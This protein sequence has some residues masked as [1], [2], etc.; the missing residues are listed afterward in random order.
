MTILALHGDDRGPTFG[1]TLRLFMGVGPAKSRI[2]ALLAISA[3]GIIASLVVPLALKDLVNFHLGLAPAGTQAALVTILVGALTAGALAEGFRSH[4]SVKAEIAAAFLLKSRLASSIIHKDA[5]FFARNESGALVSSVMNDVEALVRI[6]GSTVSLVTSCIVA[7]L[8]LLILAVLDFRLALVMAATVVVAVVLVVPVAVMSG[9]EKKRVLRSVATS[10]STLFRIFMN[11]RLVQAN[12]M[13]VYETRRAEEALARLRD[14]N[15]RMSA[16]AA[17]TAPIISFAFSGGILALAFYGSA[18]VMAGTI[19]GG[20]LAAFFAYLLGLIP[21]LFQ[22]GTSV[23]GIRMAVNSSA[24]VLSILD[25]PSPGTDIP[26]S[27]G[28]G[29]EKAVPGLGTLSIEKLKVSYDGES[30]PALAVEQLDIPPST[31]VAVTGSNGSGKSTLLATILGMHDIER[32]MA[33]WADHPI[34]D[35]DL[36][37]WRQSI[38]Y[39]SPTATLLPGTIRQNLVYGCMPLPTDA[40]I[41][42]AL[43]SVGASLFVE[44]RP[45]GLE[46]EI[47]EHGGGLSSGQSQRLALARVILQN[48]GL[49]L[50]DEATGHLDEAGAVE[51]LA[52]VRRNL[53]EATILM[54]THRPAEASAADMRYELKPA[55]NALFPEVRLRDPGRE[56]ISLPAR[57]QR[58]S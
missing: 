52:A 3:I 25:A 50:L 56:A 45:E 49:V 29:V 21:T 17:T 20:T 41:W 23:G 39:A 11:I 55:R 37:R 13:E 14:S 7:L 43:E 54:T 10:G 53:P 35:Y 51:V 30:D 26:K 47:D 27:A 32:P 24:A 9:A 4:W 22:I 28:N 2:A 46:T 57:Q 44:A 5:G 6:Y 15:V 12:V 1:Q 36:K 42:R 16:L 18:R 38:S 8:S 31:F 33:R 58:Q 40:Q 48:R 19:S 34:S